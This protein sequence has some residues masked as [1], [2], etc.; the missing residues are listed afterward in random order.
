[1]ASCASDEGP[2]LQWI[3]GELA[4]SL[5]E[6][7]SHYRLVQGCDYGQRRAWGEKGNL[8]LGSHSRW[9]FIRLIYT[10]VSVC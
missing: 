9:V 7:C 5:E 1:M 8:P 6:E 2:T 3:P 4:Q 10:R